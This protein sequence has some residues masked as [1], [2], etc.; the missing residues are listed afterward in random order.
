MKLA[1][2][3]SGCLALTAVGCS[4]N[5]VVNSPSS[6]AADVELT[7]RTVAGATIVSLKVPNML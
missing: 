4:N 5:S 3:L 1:W 7:T 2:I 6:S